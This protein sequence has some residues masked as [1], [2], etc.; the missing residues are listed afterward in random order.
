MLSFFLQDGLSII[1]IILRH[2]EADNIDYDTMLY[3]YLKVGPCLSSEITYPLPLASVLLLVRAA[4]ESL[5][6]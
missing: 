4:S 2:I 1:C 6:A 5:L 3:C